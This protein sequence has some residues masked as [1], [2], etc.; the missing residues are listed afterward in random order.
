MD[1]LVQDQ[2]IYNIGAVSRMTD[3]PASTLRIWERRYGFPQ[4]A[5][6]QGR[7][8]L[9]TERQ[10][11]SLRWIKGQI[12]QGMRTAQAIRA[13][14]QVEAQGGLPIAALP[15]ATAPSEPAG[16]REPHLEALQRQILS[17][18]MRSDLDRVDRIFLQELSRYPVEDQILRVVLPTLQDIGTAWERREATVATEHLATQYL[19]HRLAM[20]AMT[21]PPPY[22]VPP[23][24]LAC[25]PGELHEG[26]VSM[27]STLLRR[28]RWPVAYLGQ[29]VPLDD[30]AAFIKDIRPIAVVLTATR[31]ETVQSLVDW[32][33]ALSS[34]VREDRP[35]VGFGGRVFVEHPEWRARV[36]GV[37]LGDEL[38]DGLET[39]ERLLI[40]AAPPLPRTD[41]VPAPDV[42]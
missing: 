39:L 6:S 31:E 11:S 28:R 27:L 36:P 12:D 26:G 40:S 1:T 16:E 21:A 30:L 34:A 3:I 42:E 38:Q 14:G 41:R 15:H 32:P 8:R 20:W 10:V 18:L 25:V 24:V 5:R 23:T 19:R 17:H 13:L 2:P 9:Y 7:Q 29:S 35:L 4:P 33:Q 22:A 37:Y